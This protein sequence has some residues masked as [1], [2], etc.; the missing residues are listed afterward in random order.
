M[1]T[2]RVV[3][4]VRLSITTDE[5]V[6]IE[7]QLEACRNYCKARSWTIVAE[8]KDDGVSASASAP[9][10]RRGWQEVLA[11]PKGTYDVVLVWKIDRL[12]RKVLDF[13]NA[14]KALQERGAAVAAVEDPVDMSTAQG[15]AFATMLAVFAEMEAEAIR[16][17]VKAARE[18]LIKAGRVPGGAA[19][20]GYWN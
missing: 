1:S 13:L 9:E 4:Y 16:V 8:H 3:V 19:P 20:F 15:R 2:K 11:H 12:A 17:R 14:D 7:R 5:S 18:A 6:S 10:H